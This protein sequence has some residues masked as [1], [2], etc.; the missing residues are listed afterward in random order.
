MIKN[1]NGM[2][3]QKTSG[4]KQ[5]WCSELLILCKKNFDSE[6]SCLGSVSIRGEKTGVKRGDIMGCSPGKGITGDITS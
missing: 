5:N 6:K 1:E 2:K 3:I 4:V